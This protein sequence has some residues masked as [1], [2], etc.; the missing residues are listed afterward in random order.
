MIIQNIDLVAAPAVTI[1]A[2]L[3]ALIGRQT[4][5]NDMLNKFEA[6]RRPEF[7]IVMQHIVVPYTG[8]FVQAV[9]PR[10]TIREPVSYWTR[11]WNA[12]LAR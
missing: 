4:I 12:V 3:V 1:A 5:V 7:R 8:G 9:R 10:F 6:R 2:G 11:L